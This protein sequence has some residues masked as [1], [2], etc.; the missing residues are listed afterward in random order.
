MIGSG[1][2]RISPSNIR[3]FIRASTPEVLVRK[4]LAVNIAVKGQA[5]FTDITFADGK[6]YAWFLVDANKHQD[7]L[8]TINGTTN[9]TMR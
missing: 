5:D 8:E 3:M 4:Q 7:V 2:G 1:A 9:N 6:W